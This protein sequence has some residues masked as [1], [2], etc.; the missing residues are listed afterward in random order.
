VMPCALPILLLCMA[1]SAVFDDR[2]SSRERLSKGHLGAHTL[3]WPRMASAL[4]LSSVLP[5][6]HERRRPVALA[7]WYYAV[8]LVANR[9]LHG[10][11][12]LALFHRQAWYPERGQLSSGVR[13]FTEAQG[14]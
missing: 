14:R 1:L 4:A 9:P 12:G 6:A 10:F 2:Q 13:V 11:S 8:T 3:R 7:L 5:P